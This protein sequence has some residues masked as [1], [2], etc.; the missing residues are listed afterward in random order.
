MLSPL[1]RNWRSTWGSKPAPTVILPVA[2]LAALLAAEAA[3]GEGSGENRT[4]E[5]EHEG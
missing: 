1:D 2:V 3:A 5:V 4:G